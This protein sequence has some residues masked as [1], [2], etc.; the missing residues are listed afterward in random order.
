[1]QR[2]LAV[3]TI[4]SVISILAA[5]SVPCLVNAGII[6][7][8]GTPSGSSFNGSDGRAAQLTL[9]APTTITG[10]EQYLRVTVPGTAEFRV[11]TDSSNLP[12]SL[13]LS[14]VATLSATQGVEWRGIS[15]LSW[16]LAAGTYWFAIEERGTANYTRLLGLDLATF[17]PNPLP[18]ALWPTLNDPTFPFYLAAGGRTG[19]RIFGETA[20]AVP[21]PGTAGLFAAALLLTLLTGS[22]G[23][24]ASLP[25]A[26]TKRRESEA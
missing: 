8:T 6:W 24:R 7:D 17:P 14:S 20:A 19:W 2:S 12:G 16:S 15:G 23:R 21:E 3:R 11:Y 22:K 13:L 10:I 4:R 26:D 5:L 25:L 18:E 9:T 1:M